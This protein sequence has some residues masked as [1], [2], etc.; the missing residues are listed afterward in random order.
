MTN[1]RGSCGGLM[2]RE[3]GGP[4]DPRAG[5][6]FKSKGTR[7]HKGPTDSRHVPSSHPPKHRKGLSPRLQLRR[8]DFRRHIL[9]PPTC[10]VLGRRGARAPNHESTR[11]RTSQSLPKAGTHGFATTALVR[12]QVCT[13]G[14]WGGRCEGM[15]ILHLTAWHPTPFTGPAEATGCALT[16]SVD[17]AGQ[18]WADP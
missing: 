10:P 3:L 6:A 15:G 5:G 2:T 12:S 1:E 18:S 17:S 8:G 7:D 4:C 13:A 14:S 11:A 9:G 16:P